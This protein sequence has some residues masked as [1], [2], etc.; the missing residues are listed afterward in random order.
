MKGKYLKKHHVEH[1]HCTDSPF[2]YEIRDGTWHDAIC[3]RRVVIISGA[4]DNDREFEVGGM[5][6]FGNFMWPRMGPNVCESRLVRQR[7]VI[8]FFSVF[9][10]RSTAWMLGS[11]PPWAMVTPD[12]SLFS[13]S[14]LR[15][16]NCKKILFHL[17][18]LSSHFVKSFCR[19]RRLPYS[20]LVWTTLF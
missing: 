7:E 11:T 5:F 19:Q 18:A 9:L 13:S 2:L 12:S 3:S 17:Q 4:N 10:G 14:S 15:M 16:A 6:V 20:L 8:Y 1:K